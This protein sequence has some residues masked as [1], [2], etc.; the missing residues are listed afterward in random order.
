MHLKADNASV[1]RINPAK[2][3]WRRKDDSFDFL[4]IAGSKILTP[5]AAGHR[6]PNDSL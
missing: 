5:D 4:A 3:F 6:L 1:P 2:A